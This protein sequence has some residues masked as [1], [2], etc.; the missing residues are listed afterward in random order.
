PPPAGRLLVVDDDANNREV[1]V[2]F[3]Q[4]DGHTIQVAEHGAQ[5]VDLLRSHRFDLMLLDIMM[6]RMNGFQVL[7]HLSA[8]PDLCPLPVVVISALAE[9]DSI[10]RCIQMGA[11]DYLTKPW[12]QT[13]LRTRVN[14]CLEKKR[15]RDRAEELLHVVFPSAIVREL[16]ETGDIKPR[17]YEN[18][19]VLFCD[20]VG[21]T[22]YCDTHQPEDVLRYLQQLVQ[23]WEKIA[24][25]HGV[26][27]IKTIGDAF[28]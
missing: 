23:E 9:I 10:I 26:L 19:A 17:R 5:A 12:D 24:Q 4:Q 21:F 16:K 14:A 11:D 7:R 2:R 18:V 15:L 6:P 13:L 3:L 1:L 28:I 22:P 8:C 20:I 27:K 25:G